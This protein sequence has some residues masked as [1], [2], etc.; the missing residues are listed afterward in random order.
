[1]FAPQVS[2]LC[3]TGVMWGG[4]ICGYHFGIL[5]HYYTD[6]VGKLLTFGK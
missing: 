6:S 2:Q 4:V 1:M 3:D 5:Q